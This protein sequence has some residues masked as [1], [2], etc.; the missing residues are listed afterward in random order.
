V[1]KL[2]ISGLL[3]IMP[4]YI[5]CYNLSDGIFYIYFNDLNVQSHLYD[6]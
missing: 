5:I 4:W 2:L 6:K 3:V 1:L